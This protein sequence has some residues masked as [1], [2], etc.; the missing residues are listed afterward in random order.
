MHALSSTCLQFVNYQLTDT[1][2]LKTHNINNVAEPTLSVRNQA[3]LHVTHISCVKIPK[4][5][6]VTLQMYITRHATKWRAGQICGAD[7]NGDNLRISTAY[8][9][10]SDHCRVTVRIRVWIRVRV[11]VRVRIRVRVRLQIVVYK[12]LEK[13]TKCGSIT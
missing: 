10:I 7:L 3:I 2:D 11:R 1:W 8:L 5:P 6:I 9:R 4:I 12:L 13:A